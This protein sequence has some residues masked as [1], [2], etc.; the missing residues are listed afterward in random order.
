[1]RPDPWLNA[2]TKCSPPGPFPFLGALINWFGK[3]DNDWLCWVHIHFIESLYLIFFSI[4]FPFISNKNIETKIKNNTIYNHSKT[5]IHTYKFNNTCT[6]FVYWKPQS[7]GKRKPKKILSKWRYI[8][9]LIIWKTQGSKD[10]DDH[11][12]KLLI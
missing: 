11:Q 1:M 5:K 9:I 2:W 7:S 8:I 3:G 6:V 4:V 10:V 12:I